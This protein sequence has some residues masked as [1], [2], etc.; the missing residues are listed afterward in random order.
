MFYQ[1]MK[2]PIG[3]LY[4][5]SDEKSL[6]GVLFEDYWKPFQSRYSEMEQ[7]STAILKKTEEQLKQYFAGKRQEFDLPIHLDGTDF[8]KKVWMALAKI[9]YGKTRTYQE[10]ALL[11]KN[12]SAIRAVGRTNGLNPISVV[13]PCHRVVGKS[14]KLTGYA[15]GLKAKKFLLELEGLEFNDSET[16]A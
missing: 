13:L 15:G 4:L 5:V 7:A 16:L 6:R 12:P 8:Q 9:G 11:I 3:I 10:Q 1:K 14:R 2:S